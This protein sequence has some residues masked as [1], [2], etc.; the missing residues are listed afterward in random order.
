MTFVNINVVTQVKCRDFF[1]N[2]YAYLKNLPIVVT[3]SGVNTYLV[4]KPTEEEI[5]TFEIENEL[6]LSEIKEIRQQAC[7]NCGFDKLG[8]SHIHHIKPKSQGGMNHRQNL[9]TLCPNCHY[10][11]HKYVVTNYS[12]RDIT[13]EIKD[14]LKVSKLIREELK[15]GKSIKKPINIKFCKHG[16]QIGPINL[17]RFHCS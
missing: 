2:P 10:L 4:R 6:S 3:K 8:W 12:V 14:G 7:K 1:R 11:A 16:S 13:E 9:V 5:E 15:E 17:C